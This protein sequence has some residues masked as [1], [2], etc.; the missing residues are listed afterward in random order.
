MDVLSY[1]IIYALVNWAVSIA[2]QPE[3]QCNVLINENPQAWEVQAPCP[4]IKK[5]EK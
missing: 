2:Q 3:S 4:Y 1:A 5:G